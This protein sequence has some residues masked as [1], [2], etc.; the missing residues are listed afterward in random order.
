MNITQVIKK[1]II[2]EKSHRLIAEGNIYTFLVDKKANK[3][4]VKEAV[5]KLFGVTTLKAR[6][7]NIASKNKKTQKGKYIKIPGY[8]KALVELKKGDKISLFEVEGKKK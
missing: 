7:I 2:T 4:Q 8:K 1:P 3:N 5:C 6:I